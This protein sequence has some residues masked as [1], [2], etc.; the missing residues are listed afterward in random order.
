M[1]FPIAHFQSRVYFFISTQIR[2]FTEPLLTSSCW[3]AQP[4]GAS[5]ALSLHLSISVSILTFSGFPD[6]KA[7][8]LPSPIISRTPASLISLNGLAHGNPPVAY[9]ILMLVITCAVGQHTIFANVAGSP[10]KAG[11]SR[12][13]PIH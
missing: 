6:L 3:L 2:P 12:S 10:G 13:L 9:L 8:S 1:H 7:I 4:G 11:T 5:H